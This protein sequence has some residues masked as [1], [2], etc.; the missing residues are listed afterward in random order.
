MSY[1][2]P[3]IC[4]KQGGAVNILNN[5]SGFLINVDSQKQCVNQFADAMEYCIDHPD[6]VADMGQV[7]KKQVFQNCSWIKKIEFMNN[8]YAEIAK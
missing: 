1:G 5:L 4:L 2:L 3:V 6:I 7:A 8:I